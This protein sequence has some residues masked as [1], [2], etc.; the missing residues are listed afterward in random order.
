MSADRVAKSELAPVCPLETGNRGASALEQVT[1]AVRECL[2]LG[3]RVEIDGVGLLWRAPD[4]KI[5]FVP[6]NQKPRIFLAYVVEDAPIVERLFDELAARGFDPWMDRR[7]LL[8]GQNWP[9]AIEQAI[10]VADFFIACFSRKATLKRGRFQA[11]LRYALDCASEIP[12]DRVYFIPLRLEPCGV[13]ASVAQR[14]QWVDLFP[15]WEAGI[16]KLVASL[17]R[18]ESE[19]RE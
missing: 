11:E 10:S 1:R 4:G 5:G 8:P 12:L 14:Y 18:R 13:P 19:R 15:A 17:E 3:A 9:R 16:S 2:E 6:R 7:K